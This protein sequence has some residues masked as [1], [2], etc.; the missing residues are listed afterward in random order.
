LAKKLFRSESGNGSGRFQKLDP[1]PDVVP[2][3]EPDAEPEVELDPVLHPDLDAEPDPDAEL[4]PGAE[5]YAVPDVDPE[6]K[7][8]PKPN[9]D[10]FKC[11]IRIWT[12][13]KVRSGQ[14][15]SGSAS[16]LRYVT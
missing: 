3:G 2:D 5:P 15:S 1:D 7:P 12:F 4:N 14:K 9:L 10:V 6:P 13:S 11:R 8:N 16:T